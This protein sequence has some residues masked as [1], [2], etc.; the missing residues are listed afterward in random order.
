M[1]GS[2]ENRKLDLG[3]T[4]QILANIGVIAGIIFLG[5]ELRTNNELLDSQSRQARANGARQLNAAIYNAETGLADVVIK[6]KSGGELT[7]EEA[8]RLDRYLSTLI[9]DWEFWY[10]DY[11]DGVLTEEEL[12]FGGWSRLYYEV[13]PP[14]VAEI[15]EMMRA[16]SDPTFVDFME[17]NV[18]NR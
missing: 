1:I 2:M 5:M 16:H 8:I 17:A 15:W 4:T 12:R 3:Q 9:L 14:R 6:A 11:A 18:V 7:A 10:R 13:L